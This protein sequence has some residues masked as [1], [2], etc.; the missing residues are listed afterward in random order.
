MSLAFIFTEPRSRTRL[1]ELPIDT[2]MNEC[3]RYVY[4][5]CEVVVKFTAK[6]G[7]VRYALA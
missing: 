1:R 7:M 3:R 6:S 2:S 5:S 4:S